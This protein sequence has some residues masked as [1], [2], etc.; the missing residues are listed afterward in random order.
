MSA[1]NG[2]H[3]SSEVQPR[4]QRRRFTAAYKRQ[5]VEEAVQ[6]ELGQVITQSKSKSRT[7][8]H[9][10]ARCM[11]CLKLAKI[12]SFLRERPQGNQNR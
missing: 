2:K 4:V 9:L 1:S 12:F 11:S 7:L 5:I 3:P 10:E 6:P 8:T